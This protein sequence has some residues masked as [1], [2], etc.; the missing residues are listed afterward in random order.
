VVVDREGAI[1]LHHEEG[2][3]SLWGCGVF[4]RDIL[5]VV[6]VESGDDQIDVFPVL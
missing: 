6:V 5:D 4:V 2:I 1:L 3:R